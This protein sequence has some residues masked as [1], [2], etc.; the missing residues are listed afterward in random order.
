MRRVRIAIERDNGWEM[1]VVGRDGRIQGPY[2]RLETQPSSAAVYRTEQEYR[3]AIRQAQ[4]E[5]QE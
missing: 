2:T 3:A 1:T 5:R 4:R